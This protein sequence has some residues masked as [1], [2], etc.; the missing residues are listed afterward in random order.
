MSN[1]SGEENSAN[2]DSD[3]EYK[4][5]YSNAA[6]LL[7]K[8]DKYWPNWK[9][10]GL[11]LGLTSQIKVIESDK[12][13]AKD[14]MLAV[15]MEAIDQNEPISA[16]KI[17]KILRGKSIRANILA[18]KFD[19]VSKTKS[20]RI[21]KSN[22]LHCI[23]PN[24]SEEIFPY[25]QLKNMAS[26]Y[27]GLFVVYIIMQFI[28]VYDDGVLQPGKLTNTLYLNRVVLSLLH[29]ILMI[30][31]PSACYAQLCLLSHFEQAYS[32]SKY[33]GR[34]NQQAPVS[35]DISQI[36]KE[37]DLSLNFYDFF[38]QIYNWNFNVNRFQVLLH[39][40]VFPLFLCYLGVFKDVSTT[41][42]TTSW[43]RINDIQVMQIWDP[44]AVSIGLLLSGIIKDIYCIEN[45]AATI[46]VDNEHDANYSSKEVFKAIRHRWLAWD[47]FIGF[48]AVVFVVLTAILCIFGEPFIH[49][50]ATNTYT[51]NVTVSNNSL[52]NI[53]EPNNST[54]ETAQS[55][56]QMHTWNLLIILIGALHAS[57]SSANATFKQF[58]LYGYVVLPILIFGAA[59]FDE[60]N[61]KMDQIYNSFYFSDS[62]GHISLVLFTTQLVTVLNWLLC[63]QRCYWRQMHKKHEP[64]ISHFSCLGAILIVVMSLFC[65]V[66]R[67]LG[68]SFD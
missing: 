51:F 55:N 17:S 46:L 30:V 35:V 63:L 9:Y 45:Y 11:K 25:T 18:N 14:R 60:E 54:D 27:H 36:L 61:Q 47:Y 40:I 64:A 37:R 12:E 20:V 48:L 59:Y 38:V 50:P 65:I 3:A 15:L 29:A 41:N 23:K 8:L 62:P 13:G 49:N 66:I 44:I 16:S 43:L 57:G 1:T 19:K 5:E 68:N 24:I 67:E 58:C 2:E 6:D 34:K 31:I 28:T 42:K 52:L 39:A 21:T 7:D 10:F 26:Y 32:N 4:P 22:V 56:F 53:T 33:K